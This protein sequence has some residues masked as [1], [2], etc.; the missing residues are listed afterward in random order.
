MEALFALKMVLSKHIGAA[1]FTR[2]NSFYCNNYI[3]SMV[4]VEYVYICTIKSVL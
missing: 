2:F 4:L 3:K 1:I